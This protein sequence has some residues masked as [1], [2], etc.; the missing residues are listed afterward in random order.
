MQL[1][2]EA[3]EIVSGHKDIYQVCMNYEQQPVLFL[4]FLLD[5]QYAPYF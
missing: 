2:E 3:I 1:K 5:Q 4:L